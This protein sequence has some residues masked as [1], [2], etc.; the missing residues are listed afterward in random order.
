[1]V[2]RI[3]IAAAV[4]VEELIKLGLRHATPPSH[5]DNPDRAVPR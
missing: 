1:M 3:G 4:V 2:H 5:H